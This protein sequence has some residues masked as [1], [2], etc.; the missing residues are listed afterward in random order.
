MKPPLE[1]DG[2]GVNTTLGFDLSL[3][4]GGRDDEYDLFIGY[5]IEPAPAGGFYV[6]FPE[7]SGR[8]INCNSYATLEEAHEVLTA[9]AVA[10]GVLNI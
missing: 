3:F 4:N 8:D 10:D 5:T 1:A 6:N 7:A 9:C 2:Y